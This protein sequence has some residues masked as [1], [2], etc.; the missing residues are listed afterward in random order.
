MPSDLS[1][2]EARYGTRDRLTCLDFHEEKL[3]CGVHFEEYEFTF[4]GELEIDGTVYQTKVLHEC[5]EPQLF[6][7]GHRVL[8]NAAHR[9][10]PP[11]LYAITVRQNLRCEHSASDAGDAQVSALNELL[12]NYRC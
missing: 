10:C 6:L 2:E 9:P 7:C 4:R 3:A 1:S 12:E 5:S 8:G 11:V